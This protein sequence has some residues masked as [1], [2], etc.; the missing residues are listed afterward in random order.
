MGRVSLEY[1]TTTNKPKSEALRIV[2]F[3]SAA[4]AADEEVAL[5]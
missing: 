2:D 3:V 5:G 4:M 1:A